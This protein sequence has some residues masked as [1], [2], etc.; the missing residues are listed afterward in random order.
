MSRFTLTVDIDF[1]DRELCIDCPFYEYEPDPRVRYSE[2]AVSMHCRAYGANYQSMTMYGRVVEDERHPGWFRPDFS[3]S[4]H[5]GCPLEDVWMKSEN[6]RRFR[7]RKA[8]FLARQGV[9]VV[10]RCHTEFDARMA[11]DDALRWMSDAH[12]S[13][14]SLCA[15]GLQEIRS[16]RGVVIFTSAPFRMDGVKPQHVYCD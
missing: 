7:I 11:F 12:L 3:R 1:D 8:V 6:D 2:D 9:R 16:G 14:S 15:N 13:H 4:S 5:G 10:Y